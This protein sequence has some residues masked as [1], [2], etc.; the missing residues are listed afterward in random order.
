MKIAFESRL[1]KQQGMT[2]VELMVSL[3]I[4][5]VILSAVLYTYMGNKESSAFNRQMAR[6]QESGRLAIDTLGNDLRNASFT[7]CANA[8]DTRVI[9]VDDLTQLNLLKGIGVLAYPDAGGDIVERASFVGPDDG[10]F[11]GESHVLRI[12]GAM[13]LSSASVKEFPNSENA[14]LKV[15]GSSAFIAELANLPINVVVS[16]CELADIYKLTAKTESGS[17]II[18]TAPTKPFSK[19]Y[20][21]NASVFV[22]GKQLSTNYYLREAANEDGSKRTDSKGNNIISLFRDDPTLADTHQELAEGVE[23]FRVCLGL[24]EALDGTVDEY[25]LPTDVTTDADWKK[26][27]AV[28]VD[29]VMASTE[30]NV[31]D[32]DT[33]QK[34]RLCMDDPAGDPSFQKTDRRLRKLFSTTV[35]LRN[36]LK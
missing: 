13:P 11:L 28:K 6:L 8:R 34:Y 4:G 9:D 12:F 31:L 29:L 33:E 23:A 7:G 30:P 1:G 35:S 10:A 32:E 15:T 16:D 36:K 18:L 21:P 20:G 5:L 24:D 14:D 3:I 25:K 17:D 27:T 19:V 22:Y 2:V 26:V